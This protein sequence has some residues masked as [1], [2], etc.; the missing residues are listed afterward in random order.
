M[1]IIAVLYILLLCSCLLTLP[2]Y[3]ES[4]SYEYLLEIGKEE[5]NEGDYRN[6]LHYFH[7]AEIVEPS[8]QEPRSYINLIK[9][10]ID[11]RVIEETPATKKQ[12]K[13]VVEKL[14]KK[15]QA[16]PL[17]KLAP[18]RKKIPTE[19]GKQ[20]EKEPEKLTLTA[21]NQPIIIENNKD[22]QQTQQSKTKIN[23]APVY[24]G[25]KTENELKEKG[26]IELS[27]DAKDKFPLTAQL[28][29]DEFFI[30]KGSG[31]ARFL[32]INPEIILI[33][34][35]NA[36][37]VKIVAVKV[38]STFL[39]IW[40]SNA[41]WTLQIKVVPSGFFDEKQNTWEKGKGFKFMYRSDWGQYYRGRRLG[42]MKRQSLT[43]DQWAGMIGPTPYGEFDASLSWSKQNQDQ[44]VTSYT[45][46][47]TDG[48]FLGFENLKLRGFDFT[49]PFSSLSV[50]GVTLRGFSVEAPMF[51][52]NLQ[53][54]VIYGR[55][56]TYYQ[57]VLSP[58]L[59]LKQDSYIE[60][61]RLGFF[62]YKKNNFYLNYAHGYG[63]D[64]K[65]FLRSKVFSFQSNHIFPNATLASEIA[66]DE[67]KTAANV[68]YKWKLPRAILHCA[69]RNIEKDFMTISSRPSA[70]GEI[71]TLA[72]I[73]WQPTDKISFNT[74]IDVYRNKLLLKEDN[75]DALNVEWDNFAHI[76]F[77]P[78][79]N[80]S[81]SLYYTNSPGLSFPQRNLNA[82]TNYNKRFDIPLFRTHA[83]YTNIGYNYQSSVNPLSASS[84]YLRN[85]ILSG[86]RLELLRDIYLYS[87]ITYSWVDEIAS[88]TRST[89]SVM[90][91]GVDFY[92]AFRPSWATTIRAYYRD[93]QNATTIHSFLS[94][95]DSLEGTVNVTYSPKPDIQY[96]FDGRVR[97]VWAENPDVAKFIEAEAR[98][99]V[100]LAWDSFFRWTPSLRIRGIV[101]KDSN[102]DGIRS[103]AEEGVGGIKIIAGP[104]ETVTDKEGKFSISL[105]AESVYA[106][107]DMT[108]IP[109]GYIITTPSSFQ[110]SSR[111]SASQKIAFGISSTSGIAGVI[112]YDEN[113]NGKLDT[114]DTPIAKA[115]LILDGKKT[116]L[117]NDK[118]AYFFANIKPGKHSVILDVNSLPLEYLPTV[119]VKSEIEVS[120]GFTHN[121]SVP[122][123]KK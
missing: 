123:K 5:L 92:H 6:A 46:G 111:S 107:I 25:K 45:T 73:D 117:T 68:M 79:S 27:I 82:Q 51:N 121:F 63:Q 65:N 37:S 112:F 41:R 98:L 89:P 10:T 93:E 11:G 105:R 38:G 3:A 35:I 53:Y 69:F 76:T 40:D 19:P 2:A 62:P 56:S 57:S 39:H 85:S 72:G 7:L 110:V 102:A 87:N 61:L 95:E 30:V 96:F 97:N 66:S 116:T 115:K 80:L 55:E 71:G 122:L 64:R 67:K 12:Q 114:Q 15:T 32:A 48:H 43:F 108:S 94:G 119:A 52:K 101:F 100:R 81:A 75:P 24:Q 78:T 29:L 74:A 20:Y 118:G 50:P 31:I 44:K 16:Q 26:A 104:T 34:R 70:S 14:Q 120:E 54:N 28:S 33:E 4:S 91:S 84:D 18:P 8:A 86:A 83:L 42:T 113:G 103:G 17:K 36:N 13:T 49:K 21:D 23:Q 109:R 59:G 88:N 60:G 22:I 90:E 58:V 9:R 47:L 99:G 1:K 106:M 77:D